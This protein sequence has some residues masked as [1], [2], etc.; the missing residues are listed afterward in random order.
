MEVRS[1][2]V[3]R[4]KKICERKD[5]EKLKF[6]NIMANNKMKILLNTEIKFRVINK[7]ENRHTRTIYVC[8]YI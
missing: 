1:R 3:S 4:I 8:V 7:I 5:T 2:E 6:K